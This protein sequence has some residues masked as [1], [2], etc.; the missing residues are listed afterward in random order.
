MRLA[1]SK[2]KAETEGAKI[3]LAK[4]VAGYARARALAD[5]KIAAAEAE[6][7]DGTAQV[8]IA[9]AT[10]KVELAKQVRDLTVLSAPVDGTVV[11]ITSHTGDPT[12]AQQPVLYLADTTKMVA[13]AEV[14]EAD[15]S[16]FWDGLS[17]G[18]TFMAKVSSPVL[19]G[20]IR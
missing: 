12:G 6:L 14:Y 5:A 4:A 15:A 9:S 16:R 19:P 18:R 8:P 11:K 20:G 10:K 3:K 2:A 7:T 13:V 1:V 17:R